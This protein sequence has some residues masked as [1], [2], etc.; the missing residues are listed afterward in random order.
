MQPAAQQIHPFFLTLIDPVQ[1]KEYLEWSFPAQFGFFKKMIYIGIFATMFF[2]IPDFFKSGMNKSF[3]VS[4]FVRAG[5]SFTV[6]LFLLIIERKKSAI[7]FQWFLFALAAVITVNTTLV[8]II[9]QNHSVVYALSEI[10]AVMA[11][12]VLLKQ[13]F[14]YSMLSAIPASIVIISSHVFFGKLDQSSMQTIIYAFVLANTFGVVYSRNLNFSGRAQYLSLLYEQTLNARLEKEIEQRVKAQ[15]DL[16]EIART[17]AMTGLF[18]RRFFIDLADQEILK[19]HRYSQTLSLLTLD[20]DFFKNI[21]DQY[22]HAEGDL[23]LVNVSRLLASQVRKSDILARIGGEEFVVLAVHT[24]LEDAAI[25]AEN[26]R[27]IVSQAKFQTQKHIKIT[28]S[29]GV[30]QYEDGDNLTTLMQK[31]DSAL[32][33]AKNNGRDRVETYS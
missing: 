21:N 30:A 5:F 33:K 15:N 2:I 3:I 22:G 32:Y 19:C 10:I 24:K 17:D 23:A 8:I 29:I 28:L 11:M 13:R 12:Y 6:Y 1:E 26:L 4:F 18:N 9:M 20:I 25:L 27:K 14:L 31:S 16:I 7:V